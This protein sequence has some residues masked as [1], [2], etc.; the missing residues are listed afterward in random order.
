MLIYWIYFNKILSNLLD[1]KKK[2]YFYIF[3]ILAATFLFLHV[4]FLGWTFESNFLTK[5]RRI[6]IVFFIFFEVLAQAFLIKEIFSKKDKMN[7]FLNMS[8]VYMKLIFVITV[9]FSTITILL[10]LIFKDLSSEI[11]YILEW[12]YF[13]LLLLFYLLSSLMWKKN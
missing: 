4:L 2:N 7:I 9:C 6:Y 1:L 11:D 12:N 3:G 5:L 10:I 8:I 13:L